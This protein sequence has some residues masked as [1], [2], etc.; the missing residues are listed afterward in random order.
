MSLA[1]TL[2][3]YIRLYALFIKNSV[4]A[5]ME[6]RTNFITG[7]LVETAYLFAKC[8]YVIVVYQTDLHIGSI[9]PDQIL[10]FIG[11]YTFLTGIYWGLFG[12]NF[13]KLP[14]HIRNGTLEL[15]MTKPISLQFLVTLR[16]VDM[17]LALPNII[18]GITMIVISWNKVNLDVNFYT[19][20]GFI[21]FIIIGVIITYFLFLIPQILSFWFVKT[22]AI[23]D[24]SNSLWDFNNMPMTLY[25]KWAHFIG[26]YLI[27]IF[28]ITNFGPLFLY[29]E[30]KV[31]DVF[32][33]A[34]VPFILIS[35][36]RLMWNKGLRNYSSASS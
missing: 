14:E 20:G 19:V 26:M 34:G 24:V 36:M 11:T 12:I 10:M 3:R 28:I 16:H 17:G 35:S 29:D 13:I 5:Q 8:L 31:S 18:G 27:P 1:Q 15:L 23:D 6:Y 32:W 22:S 9:G 21:F 30:L 25:P 7:L 4:I 2:K 33:A